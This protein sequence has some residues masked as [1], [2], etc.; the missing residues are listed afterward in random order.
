VKNYDVGRNRYASAD[1]VFDKLNN[2]PG[3][4]A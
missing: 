4:M 3:F 1:S 2:I